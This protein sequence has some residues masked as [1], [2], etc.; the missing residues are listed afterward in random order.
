MAPKHEF[1]HD[2][3]MDVEA[4]VR[5]GARRGG[6]PGRASPPSEARRD[7]S[8]SRHDPKYLEESGQLTTLAPTPE[9][10]RRGVLGSCARSCDTSYL[11]PLVN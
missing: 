7:T 1:E 2:M 5:E 4:R 8:R 3:K 10:P 6:G 11:F 9:V